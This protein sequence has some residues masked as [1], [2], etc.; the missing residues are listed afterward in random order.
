VLCLEPEQTALVAS[1]VA[2]LI[3]TLWR[4][5]IHL[6]DCIR[7]LENERAIGLREAIEHERSRRE[8]AEGR[9]MGK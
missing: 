6:V 9:L 7:N 2:A 4:R 1:A 5:H 8:K 3:G